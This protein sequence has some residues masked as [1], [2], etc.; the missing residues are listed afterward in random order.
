MGRWRPTAKVVI[1]KRN[2]R[3]KIRQILRRVGYG[4]GLRPNENHHPPAGNSEWVHDSNLP[5]QVDVHHVDPNESQSSRYVHNREAAIGLFSDLR[6][7]FVKASVENQASSATCCGIPL[8]P[9]AEA[10][11]LRCLDC[12]PYVNYCPQCYERFHLYLPFHKPEMHEK[13]ESMIRFEK[14]KGF[15]RMV[16][17]RHLYIRKQERKYSCFQEYKGQKE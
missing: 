7:Q 1:R 14:V 2:A 16:W 10:A 9:W 3:G 5:I 12:G 4:G 17:C 13:F 15:S 8:Q 11:T 6:E